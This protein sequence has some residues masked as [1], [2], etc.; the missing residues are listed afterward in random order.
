MLRTR[1]FALY[2]I[3]MVVFGLLAAVIGIGVI[4]SRIIDEAQT[5]VRLDLE[6]AWAIMRGTQGQVSTILKLVGQKKIIGEAVEAGHWNDPELILRLENIR[7][8]FGLDFLGV[9]TPDGRVVLR[10]SAPAGSGGDLSGFQSMRQALNG[11]GGG[12]VEVFSAPQLALENTNMAG[13]AHITLEA[14][15]RARP[16][17]RQVEEQGLVLLCAEPVRGAAPEVEAVLYGGVLLNHNT[18][19]VDAICQTVFKDETYEGAHMGTATIFLEDCRIATTVLNQQGRRAIGTR[20]SAEVARRVL[21]DGQ[22]WIGR[23]FVVND[24]YLTAYDPITNGAGQVVGMLYVGM[25]EKPFTHVGQ[26]LIL[27]YGLLIVFGLIGAL[28][29]AYFLAGRLASPIHDLAQAAIHVQQGA[30]VESVPIRSSCRETEALTEAFNAMV[31]TLVAREAG[32]QRVNGELAQTVNALQATNANYMNVVGFVSH[33]LQGPVASILN[34]AYALRQGGVGQLSDAQLRVVQQMENTS[35]RMIKV[36][37][38]YLN[39][40]RI[41]TGVFHPSPAPLRVNAA[42]LHPLLQELAPEIQQAQVRVSNQVPDLAQIQ[43][44]PDMTHEVFENLLSNAIK[45]S[46]PGGQVEILCA[47]EPP[48]LRFVVRNDGV[49]LAP[50]QLDRLFQKFGRFAPQDG[51]KPVRGTGLGLFITKHIIEAH[52][53]TIAAESTPG[54]WTAFSFTL[55]LNIES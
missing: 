40:S 3:L 41:E 53:G 7:Q 11:E 45:Y 6:S 47:P 14:T 27:R 32:L 48:L 8:R 34:Y 17:G 30:Q 50:A 35:N 4:K 49:G 15:P 2:A 51:T 42:I 5:R 43:A 21:D 37:R 18:A 20:A 26:T 52:G 22:P 55:P 28:L 36:I 23:A 38:H 13:R 54:G 1:L 39:L 19:L 10:T 44:D 12:G 29:A 31:R 46:H 33:E 16:S 24:W 9:M 25:L